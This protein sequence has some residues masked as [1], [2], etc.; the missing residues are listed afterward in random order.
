MT[1]RR[2]DRVRVTYEAEWA[3]AA[4]VPLATEIVGYVVAP[5][6]VGYQCG[7]PV[8]ATVEVLRPSEPSWSKTKDAVALSSYRIA[9]QCQSDGLWY[10]PN[11][12]PPLSYREWEDRYGPIRLVYD[13]SAES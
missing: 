10:P 3:S 5:G 1:P 2:G 12:D 9:R 8:S 13:P 6:S 11:E 4:G 7:I